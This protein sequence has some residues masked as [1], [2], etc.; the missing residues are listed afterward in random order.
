MEIIDGKSGLDESRHIAHCAGHMLSLICARLWFPY[1]FIISILTLVT[2]AKE[3][4]IH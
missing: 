4:A 3:E 1:S 2:I